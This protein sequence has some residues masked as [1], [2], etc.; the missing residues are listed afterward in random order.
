[1]LRL[2]GRV[3]GEL[4]VERGLE[5]EELLGFSEG[6]RGPVGLGLQRHLERGAGLCSRERRWLV[7]GYCGRSEEVEQG[8][9]VA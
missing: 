4:G 9:E 7:R 3:R 5:R 1:M 8:E 2:R 6:G